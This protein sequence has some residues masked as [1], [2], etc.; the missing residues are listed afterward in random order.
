MN[1]NDRQLK[2]QLE[3]LPGVE[4]S[5]SGQDKV[6]SKNVTQ[7]MVEGNIFFGGGTKLG[8]E[9]IPAD[10][11]DKVEVID[12]F[13]QV[14]HMKEVSGSDD[15]AMNIKLKEDKKKFV[16]GDIRAGAGNNKFYE[17]NDSLFCCSSNITVNDRIQL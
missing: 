4:V 15:L 10:A 6:Q 3:K 5:D 11:V 14:G 13:T 17:D 2:D 7:F 12:H 9:N 16:F 8:V 1:G